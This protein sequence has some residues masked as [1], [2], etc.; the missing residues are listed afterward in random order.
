MFCPLRAPFPYAGG[1]PKR[2]PLHS[3]KLRRDRPFRFLF[4]PLRV[5]G[6][7]LKRG[8]IPVQR[9]VDFNQ[10]VDA[11]ILCRNPMFLREMASMSFT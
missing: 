10:G 7:K 3:L 5:P 6:A 4:C 11:R 1:Q 2:F 8:T 9:R